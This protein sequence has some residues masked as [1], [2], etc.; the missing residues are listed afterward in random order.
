MSQNNKPEWF[1]I[2]EKDE[3][4]ELR[5]VSKT[6]PTSAV[7]VAALILGA[8]VVVGQTQ[9]E[10]P[11]VPVSSQLIQ[12]P[13]T[14]ATTAAVVTATT[15]DKLVN[16]SISQLPVGGGD[17][18]DDDDHGRDHEDEGDEDDDHEDEGD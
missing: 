16:P 17:D 2:I 12:T 6:L 8:G 14:T 10:K 7:L 13:N 1:E 3:K 5:K 4:A 15:A 11:S 9:L 18:E